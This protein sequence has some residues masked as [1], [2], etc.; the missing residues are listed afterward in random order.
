[1]CIKTEILLDDVYYYEVK[2]YEEYRKKG[3]KT[4]EDDKYLTERGKKAKRRY[5]YIRKRL[6]IILPIAILVLVILSVLGIMKDS[7][8]YSLVGMAAIYGINFLFVL[9]ETIIGWCH[10]SFVPLI[11]A[12]LPPPFMPYTISICIYIFNIVLLIG[13]IT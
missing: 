11:P 3:G 12:R 7:D 10:L 8:Y 4:D 1:M 9:F 2:R 6:K 13:W 5:W